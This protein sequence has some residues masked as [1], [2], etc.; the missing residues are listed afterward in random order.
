MVLS[1][2]RMAGPDLISLRRANVVIIE[3]VLRRREGWLDL[4]GSVGF[5]WGSE[6]AFLG[7]GGPKGNEL[8]EVFLLFCSKDPRALTPS[9]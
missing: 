8:W 7:R 6:G 1:E 5:S 4:E 2:H 3:K 9:F